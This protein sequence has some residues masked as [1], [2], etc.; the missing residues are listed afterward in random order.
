MATNISA[1][2]LVALAQNLYRAHSGCGEPVPIEDRPY[3]LKL[4]RVAAGFFRTSMLEPGMKSN[5]VAS[6]GTPKTMVEV[7][8]IRYPTLVTIRLPD[9]STRE[10]EHDALVNWGADFGWLTADGKRLCHIDTFNPNPG[11]HPLTGEPWRGRIQ[12][13]ALKTMAL[14]EEQCQGQPP[15]GEPDEKHSLG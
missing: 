13:D 7:V 8:S 5:L 2:A 6:G 4:A 9:G 3:W 1:E 14:F 15:V 12:P 10:A 11:P